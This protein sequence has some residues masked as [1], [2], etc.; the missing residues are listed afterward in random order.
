MS[1][2]TLSTL[3]K[4][5]CCRSFY[6]ITREFEEIK[7]I[8]FDSRHVKPGHIFVAVKG[9]KYDGH[10]YIEEA[11]TKGAKAVVAEKKSPEGCPVAWLEV[12]DTR[13]ALAQLA[14]AYFHKPSGEL[15]LTGVTGTSGK[16]TTT[17]MLQEIYHTAGLNTGLIGTL[18]IKCRRQVWPARLTTPDSFELQKLLRYMVDSGVSHAAME[19]SSHGLAL[20]RVDGTE[21]RGA[22]F[23]NISPNH[24]DFHLD[25]KNYSKAKVRLASL[26]HP[27]GFIL[28]NGDD[29]VLQQ[30]YFPTKIVPI[31]FGTGG[32]ND[33]I[34]ENISLS[35]NGSR[36]QLKIKN[37]NSMGK[38]HLPKEASFQVF[39]LGRHN[40]FNAAAAASAAFLA[41]IDEESIVAGLSSFR[42]VERRM[43]PHRLGELNIIDDTA[44]NP[45]SIDAV[46]RTVDELSLPNPVVVYAIRGSRGTEV[47]ED[48]GRS[49][50][51]WVKALNIRHFI[52]TCSTGHVDEEN[53]VLPEEKEAFLRGAFSAGR[54]PEHFTELPEALAQAVKVASPGST[55]LLLGAQ[56]MDAGLKILQEQLQEEKVFSDRVSYIKDNQY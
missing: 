44:M 51:R 26:V 54:F 2:I 34:I 23:T 48:N 22:V 8:S 19:V 43:Q 20:K 32:A 14:V 12:S 49:L 45:G 33:F 3:I 24:L 11:I 21:F 28:V 27:E 1:V 31:F 39:V 16:T 13:L 55:L 35:E 42:V 52:C 41:G 7:G 50:A 4:E 29:P 38:I 53:E 9:E 47:N 36:F 37:R 5:L 15:F 30:Q 6:N 56:G 25:L 17:C 18:Y 46:F 40:V 10:G